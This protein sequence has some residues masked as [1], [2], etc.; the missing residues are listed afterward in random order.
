MPA[1]LPYE[2][3]EFLSAEHIC[4]PYVHQLQPFPLLDTNK[5]LEKVTFLLPMPW[6][7]KEQLPGH[8][9]SGNLKRYSHTLKEPCKR[10]NLQQAHGKITDMNKEQAPQLQSSGQYSLNAIITK[11]FNWE[12]AHTEN[13]L[14]LVIWFFLL[15]VSSMLTSV[16]WCF[17]ECFYL[18]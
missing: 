15:N 17:R 5:C 12:I 16:P 13:M 11:L 10:L 3:E 7:G 4:T 2:L 6:Q 1:D 18:L 14:F 8:G 9:V